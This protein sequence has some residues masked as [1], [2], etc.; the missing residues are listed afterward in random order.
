[1]EAEREVENEF[2]EL[3]I[4]KIERITS[5]FKPDSFKSQ[6]LPKIDLEQAIKAVKK[7]LGSMH[8]LLR[9]RT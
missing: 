7:G 9:N 1:M 6:V 8:N 5:V 4:K 3:I 2:I